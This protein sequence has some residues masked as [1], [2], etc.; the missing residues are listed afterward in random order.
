MLGPVTYLVETSESKQ[1]WKRHLDQLKELNDETALPTSQDEIPFVPESEPE[2]SEPEPPEVEQPHDSTV[3][4]T[5]SNE[6]EPISDPEPVPEP[7]AT[8]STAPVSKYPRRVKTTTRL[9]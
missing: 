6:T 3:D 7:V 1:V 5:G 8:P 9:V 4:V 2:S